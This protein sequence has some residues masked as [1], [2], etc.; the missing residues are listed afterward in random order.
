MA[1]TAWAQQTDP[2]DLRG[3]WQAKGS[4]YR[5]I[6]TVKGVIVDPSNAKI[7]YR[8]DAQPTVERNKRERATADTLLACF[9]P[10]IPRAT[11][12]PEPFQIFQKEDRVAIVYQHVHAYRVIFTDGRTHYDDGIE[13]YMGDSRGHWEGNTL[14]VETTNFNGKAGITGNGRATYTSDAIRLVERFTRVDRDTLQY[15]ATID[16][17]TMW[18]RPW[19]IAFPLKQ[20]SLTSVH[21]KNV[22]HGHI[23]TLHIW[24]A[25]RPLAASRAALIAT[26]L[27]DPDN[28]AE[29]K[30]IVQNFRIGFPQ[31]FQLRQHGSPTPPGLH[32]RHSSSWVERVATCPDRM[33]A[34]RSAVGILG[35]YRNPITHA[36]QSTQAPLFTLGLFARPVPFHHNGITAQAAKAGIGEQGV[37]RSFDINLQQID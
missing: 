30:E 32:V 25:R 31:L 26:L 10:G 4:A 33:Q 11:L 13:F 9:Q 1:A 16:D 15:E 21:E 5:D 17:P 12:L 20:A 6:E 2:R 24:P 18:T 35:N 7:P 22:R 8:P 37:F 36:F 34:S 19:T 29:R 14:V 28:D 23:S 27:P 3:I